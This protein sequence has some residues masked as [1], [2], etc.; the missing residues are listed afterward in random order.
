MLRFVAKRLLLAI[1][2]FA[3]TAYFGPTYALIQKLASDTNRALAVA[4]FVLPSGLI[5]L[6]L[7]PVFVGTLSDAFSGGI[8]AD[9]GAGLQRALGVLA[10]FYFWAAFHFW[11]AQVSLTKRASLAQRTEH[12]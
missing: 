1:P 4:L 8:K 12:L 2:T 10:L 5:G 9:E 3:A 6:G 7:G 11:R